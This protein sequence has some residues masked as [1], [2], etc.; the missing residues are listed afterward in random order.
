M[1]LAPAA[2][3]EVGEQTRKRQQAL[4]GGKSACYDFLAEPIWL[5]ID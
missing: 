5:V 3:W 1:P 4:F 2:F